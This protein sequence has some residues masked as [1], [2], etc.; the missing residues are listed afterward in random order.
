MSEFFIKLKSFLMYLYKKIVNYIKKS[1]ITGTLILINTI[2]LIVILIMGGFSN[3][4][5]AQL[6]GLIPSRVKDFNEYYRLLSAMFLHGSILH[7]LFNAYFLHYFGTFIEKLLGKVKFLIIYLLSGLGSSLLVLFL[8]QSN[9]ITI[10]ASGALFGVLGALLVLT[11]IKE[12]WFHPFAI[13]NI[14][15]VAIINLIFTFLMPKISVL[16]HLGGFITGAILIYFLTPNKKSL[17]DI[18]NKN[19]DKSFNIDDYEIIDHEDDTSYYS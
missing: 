15:T 13:K 17:K 8:G 6:G 19:N 12:E 2:M 1:P 4:N 11:V 3:A 7:F 9:T 18:I 16:G 14:R 5:L 10:G